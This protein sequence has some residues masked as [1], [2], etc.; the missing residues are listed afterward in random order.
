MFGNQSPTNSFSNL[1]HNVPFLGGLLSAAFNAGA[2]VGDKVGKGLIRGLLSEV[3]GGR[4]RGLLSVGLAG[5]LTALVS[6]SV[7]LAVAQARSRLDLSQASGMSLSQASGAVSNLK[8][9]GIDAESVPGVSNN[10]FFQRM[11]SSVYGVRGM[12]GST[13]YLSSYR[14]RYQSAA[15]QGEMGFKQAQNMEGALGMTGARFM[16]NLSQP[17]F[18][19]QIKRSDAIQGAFG[20]KPDDIKRAAVDFSLF[21]ASLSQFIE[22]GLAKIGTTILPYLTGMLDHAID[23]ISANGEKF[24]EGLVSAVQSGM[25][26]LI[27]FGKWLYASFPVIVVDVLRF[28]N[29]VIGGFAKSVIGGVDFVRGPVTGLFNGIGRMAVGVGN[30]VKDILKVIAGTPL[31][32]SVLGALGVSSETAGNGTSQSDPAGNGTNRPKTAADRRKKAEQD[33]IDRYS[34]TPSGNVNMGLGGHNESGGLPGWVLTAGGLWI[35]SKAAKAAKGVWDVGKVAWNVGK[36]M[37]NAVAAPVGG[38]INQWARPPLSLTGGGLG[39]AAKMPLTYVA[40]IAAGTAGYEVLRRTGLLGK[41]MPS[42]YQ[43]GKYGYRRL[44]GDSVNEAALASKGTPDES[45]SDGS[46]GA[47]RSRVTPRG[48]ERSRITM[49]AD[50]QFKW[51][52]YN[53][54]DMFGGLRNGA[55]GVSDWSDKADETLAGWQKSLG[56]MEERGKGFDAFT[57]LDEIAKNTK[58]SADANEKMPSILNQFGQQIVSR[59]LAYEKQDTTRNLWRGASSI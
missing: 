41:D 54:N 45:G 28:L 25:N 44:M 36:F 53:A 47:E 51:N 33:V 35:A 37:W 14:D 5:A 15:A 22:L 17:D 16:A 29:G 12:P 3:G 40:G 55:Q 42:A 58:R 21:N 39:N 48:A 23:W 8:A 2:D 43:I 26:A 11:Q 57:K 32:K 49:G 52:D 10:S 6:G 13:E 34:Q 24:S 4:F 38:P 59:A 50:G 1:L 9:F 27:A 30:I 46:R 7:A 18:D 19:R 56:T 20:M 31:I